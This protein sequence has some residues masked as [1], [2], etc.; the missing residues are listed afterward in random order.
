MSRKRELASADEILI[1]TVEQYPFLY[2]HEHKDFKDFQIRENCWNDIASALG[3]RPDECKSRWKNIRD[4]FLKHK[5]K[6]KI[7]TGSA[8]SAKPPKWAL[9]EYLKFLDNVKSERQT[10]SNVNEAATGIEENID[11]E[12]SE[13]EVDT[14]LDVDNA[15][16]DDDLSSPPPSDYPR[17][18]KKLRQNAIDKS[19]S[20]TPDSYAGSTSSKR[21]QRKNL[22]LE[23]V[24]ERSKQ[25]MQ[26][27]SALT[28]KPEDDE[29]DLFFKSIAMTVKKLPPHQIAKAKL[30][31]LT[32][33]TELQASPELHT[34]EPTRTC[35]SRSQQ[36]LLA[37]LTSVSTV[38]STPSSQEN[39]VL[40]PLTSVSVYNSSDM[41]YS[42]ENIRYG[43]TNQ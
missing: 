1:R 22:F 31:I 27:L 19:R 3:K 2:D 5:R 32:L 20:S 39:V 40:T 4:N 34:N 23:N 18:E 28:Q 14:S 26:M 16:V 7:G 35:T 38:S 13:E 21:S 30:G 11:R 24:E 37:P 8:A 41:Q 29:I 6:Q 25:R 15:L 17:Q 9:F 12:L 42:L 10:I 43:W 36:N 33:V